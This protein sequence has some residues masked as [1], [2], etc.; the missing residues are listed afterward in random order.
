MKIFSFYNTVP[1]HDVEGELRLVHLWADHWTALGYEPTVLN[2]VHARKH[3]YFHE[4]NN[5]ISQLPTV[6]SL[7]YERSCFVRHLAFAQVGGGFCSDY[8]VFSPLPSVQFPT[9]DSDELNKLQ[10]LQTNCI[11]PCLF[12][13]TKE[14]LERMCREFATSKLGRRQMGERTQVSD[15]YILVDLVE[16][17]KADWIAQSNLLLGYGDDGWQKAEFVHFS[18]SSCQPRGMVPRWKHIPKLLQELR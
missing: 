4:Y 14:T 3:P 12:Y 1:S 2:E 18:N 8:D 13:A 16:Q 11:C 6:N 9:F 15:Q 5:A 17:E 10:L 7:A